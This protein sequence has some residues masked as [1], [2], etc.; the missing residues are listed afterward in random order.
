MCSAAVLANQL[1][2]EKEDRRLQE[3]CVQKRRKRLLPDMFDV[4]EIL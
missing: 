4:M 1:R 2:A 3:G